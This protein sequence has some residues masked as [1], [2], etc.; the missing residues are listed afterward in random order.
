[1]E[2]N[3]WFYSTI[4]HYGC[5]DRFLTL[6]KTKKVDSKMMSVNMISILKDY[7]NNFIL[8]N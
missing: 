8:K 6:L 2:L 7:Q 4:N 1:M 5:K 3:F